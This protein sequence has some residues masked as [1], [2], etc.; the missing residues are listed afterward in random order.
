MKY[1]IGV[2]KLSRYFLPAVFANEVVHSDVAGTPSFKECDLLGAGFVNMSA[3]H[4]R[5]FNEI[6]IGKS[7]SLNLKP[8]LVDGII[9][10]LFLHKGLSG[11]QLSNYLALCD[12]K[13]G[14]AE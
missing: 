8:S 1:I 5:N 4:R 13:E 9:L 12:F 3:V 10:H 14:G 2:H 11:L 6:A 7:D